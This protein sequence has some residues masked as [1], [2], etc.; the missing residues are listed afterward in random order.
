MGNVGE[1]ILEKSGEE[2]TKIG[3]FIKHYTSLPGYVTHSVIID[4]IQCQ[5]KKVKG[6]TAI[7]AYIVYY[8]YIYRETVLAIEILCKLSITLTKN[9]KHGKIYIEN[10]LFLLRQ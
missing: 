7:Y 5:R 8:F 9:R 2:D 3:G 10:V 4:N 1:N 6:Y